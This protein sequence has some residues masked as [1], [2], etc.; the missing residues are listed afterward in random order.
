MMNKIYSKTPQH[1][2][3][4]PSPFFYD[5]FPCDVIKKEEDENDFAN[6]FNLNFITNDNND[7]FKKEE[8]FFE[9]DFFNMN[10]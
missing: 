4:N 10:K 2:V 9:E 1:T 5:P 3:V 6:P 7:H 8:D